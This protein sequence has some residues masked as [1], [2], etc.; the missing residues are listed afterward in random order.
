MNL[1]L[2]GKIAFVGGA[3][4][5]LGEAVARALA[6]E[7]CALALAARRESELARVAGDIRRD[8]GADVLTIPADFTDRTGLEHAVRATLERFGHADIL[9]NNAGGPPS[10]PFEDT[11]PELWDGAYRLLLAGAVALT[12]GFLPG[13]RER[14]WGRVINIT[15][16]A[17]KQ[18]VENLILSN[19]I[20]SAVT[21]F[22]RTLANE[23]ASCNVTVNCVLPGY[24]KTQRIEYL[25]R[26]AMEHDGITYEEAIGKWT[27]QIPM[28]RMAE[29]WELADLV[30]F[31]ASERAS[32]ITGQSIAVDGGWIKSLL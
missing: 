18:P 14:R 16:I 27:D 19:S 24:T 3:S 8:H 29:P 21:G 5:G 20:R 28:G 2:Q 7:G 32:Y 26:Q 10:M 11:T 4:S 6:A 25:A 30:A 23:A 13:M 9:V 22:S 1:G 12:R 17:V 31:L 15:S